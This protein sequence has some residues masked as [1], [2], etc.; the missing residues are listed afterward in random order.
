MKTRDVVIGFVFLVILIAGII[1]IFRIKNKKEVSEPLPTPNISQDIKSA[2][3]NLDIPEGVENT[4]LHDVTGGDSIGVATRTEVVANLPDPSNSKKYEVLL[5]N[6]EGKILNIGEMKVSKSG[7]ILEYNSTKFPGYDKIIIILG[8][9]PVL[10][11]S[12]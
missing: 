9:S 1:F 2:F 10:E 12:F 11:G 7:Y 4:K 6:K 8:T 5:E 3:P